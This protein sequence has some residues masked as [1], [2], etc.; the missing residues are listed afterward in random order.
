MGNPADFEE[1]YSDIVP[2]VGVDGEAFFGDVGCFG[3]NVSLLFFEAVERAQPDDD[4][5][6]VIVGASEGDFVAVGFL[7]GGV[8]IP[9]G[10]CPTGILGPVTHLENRVIGQHTQP[11]RSAFMDEGIIPRIEA[12]FEITFPDFRRGSPKADIGFGVRID[13]VEPDCDVFA[14]VEG[15]RAGILLW[16]FVVRHVVAQIRSPVYLFSGLGWGFA[17][18]VRQE[19]FVAILGCH[20]CFN[21]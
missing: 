13:G 16:G 4:V 20:G 2:D 7:V 21:E 10:P 14:G 17:T 15:E 8:F 1:P 5:G 3:L 11:G 19:S 9:I 12:D 18:R 6:R